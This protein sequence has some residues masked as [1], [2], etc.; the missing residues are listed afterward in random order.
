MGISGQ[1]V[2]VA[3]H[4]LRRDGWIT[5]LAWRQT[6]AVRAIIYSPEPADDATPT[7]IIGSPNRPAAEFAAALPD[8]ALV[9]GPRMAL[10]DSAPGDDEGDLVQLPFAPQAVPGWLREFVVGDDL[11]EGYAALAACVARVGAGP[12]PPDRLDATVIRLLTLHHWRRLR[13]RHAHLPDALLND[14]WEGARARRAVMAVLARYPRPEIAVL[15]GGDRTAA[16]DRCR[17]DGLRPGAQPPH[18]S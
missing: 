6:E 8:G 18:R 17:K 11:R 13:L 16:R 5:D 4:R 7:L 10:T 2:R 3:I 1:A 14:N 15:S 12:V 9:I